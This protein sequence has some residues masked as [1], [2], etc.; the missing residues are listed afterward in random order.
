MPTEIFLPDCMLECFQYLYPTIDF[1]KIHFYDGI[2]YPYSLGGE[3]GLTL[4][5]GFGTGIHVHL[6]SGQWNPCSYAAFL[7][8]AHELV[9]VLQIKNLPYE[10]LWTELYLRNFVR[11]GFAYDCS[12]ALEREAYEHVNGCSPL[13]G[14]GGDLGNCI[15]TWNPKL[16]APC[17]CSTAPVYRFSMFSG[18]TFLDMLK[19]NCSKLVMSE[20]SIPYN[21]SLSSF[22][23]AM[24]VDVLALPTSTELVAGLGTAGIVIGIIAAIL[25]LGLTPWLIPGILLGMLAG[26][27]VG[28]LL[29]SLI[30]WIGGL[31]SGPS[32]SLFQAYIEDD[33]SGV[34]NLGGGSTRIRRRFLAQTDL[35]IFRARTTRFGK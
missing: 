13:G 1:S 18:G 19:A 34:I 10:G 35:C 32:N 15:A 22:I 3:S 11:S 26:W 27:L 12:N 33:G 7:M 17:D 23:G 25:L 14:G 9:H 20:S 2:P 16:V 4:A 21:G 8:L 30:S 31:F 5:L 24:I 6:A 29:G 28:G